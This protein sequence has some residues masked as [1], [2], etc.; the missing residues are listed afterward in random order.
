MARRAFTLIEVLVITAI[1]GTLVGVLLPALSGARDA[2]RGAV[3]S[4]NVRQFGV[5]WTMYAGDHD[6]LAMPL[7]YTDPADTGG[8]DSVY[9]WGADGSASGSLDHSRG[10]LSS[11]LDAK[12][13]EIG[14]FACPAQR[15]GTYAHQGAT[16]APTSTYGYNGYYLSP[17][18]TP[19]WSYEI[20]HRPHQR[21]SGIADPASLLV[22]ADT[23]I[24]RGPMV[25]PASNALL[26]P[27]MLYAGAGPDG[28][29]WRR[30][31]FPTTCFRH[32][33]LG[34]GASCMAVHADGSA[35]GYRAEAGWLT[36][37][38]RGIGSVGIHNGP[39]YIP[40]WRVWR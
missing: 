38:A 11:Y 22:F 35:R 27:P 9:W 40:D 19:G 34:A 36:Q 26:D 30:N 23:L 13:G 8:G 25:L 29:R 17:A 6:G 28:A 1:V 31:G 16:Q 18:Y 39:R 24:S 20:G 4:S 33:G 15:P 10:L 7:A 2:A 32:G 14:P 21:L 37:P 3:C 5:A 12:P